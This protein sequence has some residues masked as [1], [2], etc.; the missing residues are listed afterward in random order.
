MRSHTCDD[1]A[2]SETGDGTRR[3]RTRSI[4]I[5]VIDNGIGSRRESDEYSRTASTRK[6]GHGFGLHSGAL[7]ARELVDPHRAQRRSGCSAPLSSIS[8]NPE[9]ESRMMLDPHSRNLRILVIDDNRAIH[10]DFRKVLRGDRASDNTLDDFEAGLFGARERRVRSRLNSI[11]RSRP[12]GTGAGDESRRGRA[13]RW[14]L[15]CACRGLGRHRDHRALLGSRPNVRCD[16]YGVFGCS[17]DDMMAARSF[18]PVA[19]SQSRSTTSRS[20]TRRRTDREM[21]SAAQSACAWTISNILRQR[22]TNSSRRW[23]G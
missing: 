23:S 2:G 22:T 21:A 11:R 15:W 7:A 3:R 4:L 6:N 1:S 13:A 19:D 20:S 8:L 16:L 17:W 14:H 18:R 9:S 5:S 12:G 10:E